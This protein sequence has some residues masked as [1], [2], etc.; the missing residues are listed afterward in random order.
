MPRRHAILG[1]F[2]REGAKYPISV[3]YQVKVFVGESP[4]FP[5]AACSRVVVSPA[6]GGV[7]EHGAR[8]YLNLHAGHAG[9]LPG[10]RA[11][12]APP[13]E[14]KKIGGGH[15]IGRPAVFQPRN[16]FAAPLPCAGTRVETG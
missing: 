3:F 15:G 10:C 1:W 16:V 6:V 12:K 8:Q 5:A 14:E 7:R 11:E 2:I 13:K 4:K 9:S